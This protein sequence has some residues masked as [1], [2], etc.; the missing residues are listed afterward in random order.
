MMEIK[1]AE[2]LKSA[3]NPSHYPNYP[4]PEFAFIG[5]SN[6]G[7]SSL[8]NMILGNRSLV[9][10]SS[11]PGH[12]QTINFFI[13]N[14]AISIA[15]LPGF[16]FAQ[17]PGKIRKSFIPMITR[18]LEERKNLKIAFLLVDARRNIEDEERD[19]IH[20]LSGNRISTAIVVT[21]IDKLTKNELASK[22]RE[23]AES[24]DIAPEDLFLTSSTKKS[25]YAEILSLISENAKR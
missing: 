13:I 8:I 22:K 17:A 10:T 15:D 21:K 3:T 4:Y 7:K 11:R 18:Y 19:F 9:K 1:K 14:D 23:F 5:R 6:V 25:G 16:G 2:F 20:L 24:L 12:T